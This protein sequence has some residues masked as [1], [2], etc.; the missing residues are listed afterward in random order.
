MSKLATIPAQGAA[1]SL[2]CAPCSDVCLKAALAKGWSP[3][4]SEQRLLLCPASRAG[5]GSCTKQGCFPLCCD[6]RSLGTHSQLLLPSAAPQSL[7]LPQGIKRLL[8]ELKGPASPC[9][10]S[11]S[12][13]LPKI[14]FSFVLLGCG[15]SLQHRDARGTGWVPLGAAGARGPALLW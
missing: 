5:S 14:I 7:P 2:Q 11:G 6:G 15:Y 8:K 3:G 4:D 12:V 1:V 13:P 9:W 10:G